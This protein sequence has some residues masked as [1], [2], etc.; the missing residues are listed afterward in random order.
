MNHPVL[1]LPPDLQA[2][3]AAL[4]QAI[5]RPRYSDTV[6]AMLLDHGLICESELAELR[7]DDVATL[8]A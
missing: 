3:F 2:Q 5:P 7:R 4:I 8:Q 6:R 1:T